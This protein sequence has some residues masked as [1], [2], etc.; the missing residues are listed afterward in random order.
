M[1]FLLLVL[2]VLAFPAAAQQEA[3]NARR[4][5]TAVEGLLKQRPTDATL[6]YFLARANAQLGDKAATLAALDKTNEH[7]D[8]FLPS[9][10]AFDKVWEDAQFQALRGK[11]EARLPTL[12][13]AP[14]AFE[15]DDRTLLPEGIAYDAPSRSFF[16]GSAQRR[17][18]RVTESGVA[19]EFAGS[20]AD[21]DSVL[22]LAVDAPRR[23]L[24]VVS[25]SALTTEGE[26]RRRNAVVAFDVDTRK[27]LARYE[28]PGAVQLN[29]VTVAMGGRVFATDSGSGAVYE[30][31]VKGPLTSRE[32]LPAARLGGSNGLAASP[33]G[34]KLYVAHSTGLAVIDLASGTM[35]R[36]ANPT[37]E[38]VAA[39]DGLYQWQG[40]LIGVQNLTTPGRV[41]VITLAS[42]GETVAR[43]QTML[44]HH[45]N[46]LDEPTTGVVTERGFFLLAA[47]GITHFNRAGGIDDP[48]KVPQPRV[49]R[50][51][52]PR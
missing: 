12:D 29:D 22:G 38:T 10:P 3:E 39:I 34:S 16:I 4:I 17:V 25:T 23:T 14:T 46:A 18:L 11:M 33:N 31:G 24:Y 26:K 19:S 6:W 36:V 51:P 13:F 44:S 2:L 35:K 5:V 32:V 28:V 30:I 7:G 45:H 15:L 9:R 40:Q 52:L 50:I 41:I 37:R 8:G 48:E 49:L 1:R 47:T 42:D 21:L 43:V 27:L 20:A